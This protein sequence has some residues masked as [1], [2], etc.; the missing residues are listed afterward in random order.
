MK[1][2]NEALFARRVLLHRDLVDTE[3]RQIKID[4]SLIERELKE[5][6]LRYERIIGPNGRV[7]EERKFDQSKNLIQ[8][9][10]FSYDGQLLSRLDVYDQS[11][12]H[13]KMARY[14]YTAIGRLRKHSVI[15][16]NNNV[17]TSEVL[18]SQEITLYFSKWKVNRRNVK[19]ID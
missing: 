8:R 10:L 5:G 4:Q 15:N 3:W 14:F 19:L 13:V 12:K 16:Y 1:H 11:G 18:D 7:D 2:V 9:E 6:I 17:Q